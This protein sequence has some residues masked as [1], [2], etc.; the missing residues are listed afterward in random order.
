[1]KHVLKVLSLALLLLFISACNSD[2][3]KKVKKDDKNVTVLP[4]AKAGFRIYP[5][6]QQPSHESMTLVWFSELGTPGTVSVNGKTYTSTPVYQKLLEY[7]KKEKEQEIKGLTK[8]SWLKSNSN[9]KHVVDIEGLSANTKYK[10]TVT[11]DG[12]K[13]EEAFKT[14][15]KQESWESIKVIAFAD[16]ETEPYGRIQRREWELSFKN[17][18]AQGSLGRPGK[19]SAWDK[20]FGNK[21]R[22]GK[23]N[24][25]YPLTQDEALKQNVSYIMEAKPDLMMVVGDLVQGGG[26]QAAWDEYFR[27]FAGEVSNLGSKVPVLTAL[28]NWETYAALNGGYGSKEDRSPV[29]ISRNK[30]HIYTQTK[31]DTNNPQYKNSYYRTDYGPL[32]ILTLDSTN[33][34]PDEDV[35]EKLF[36]GELF[37]GN[38]KNITAKTKSTDTQGSFKGS[39]YVA[40]FPK[41]FKGK[42][43]QDSDLPDFNPG[44]D[45]YKWVEAQLKDARQKG[46]VIIAQWH[47]TAYSQG[48]HGRPP[49]FKDAPDNQS[50]VAMRVYTPLL[51]KYGVAAVISGHD[52]MFERSFVDANNDGI[53]LQVYDVGIAADGLR[54]ESYKKLEDGS[55]VPHN[56]NTHS[57]WSASAN[58]PEVWKKDSS[59]V[60]QLQD[61]GLHYGHLEM[62]LKKTQNGATLT[63]TPVYIFPILDSKYNL[64]KTERRVYNDVVI[65]KLNKNGET[66]K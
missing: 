63:I 31:G 39:K 29:V 52:E 1:M 58:E 43:A 4:K 62:D 46:Q 64:V 50:G 24:L 2:N 40:A 41:V 21:N 10:Y 49:N 11:Q 44:S 38:D 13:Y 14:A 56:F 51:E 25:K 48:V 23:F 57:K 54:G 36:S 32:T 66:I 5:Y 17:P 34:L 9:Y 60:L 27:Y 65:I 8:G 30:Y 19:D 59:G 18:Y 7:T 22:Y 53:G 61:G 37:S 15:P 42:T 45:Q 3:D 26:Y 28:G 55:L 35:K 16:T 47:H 20:K 33:G 12:V 6:L